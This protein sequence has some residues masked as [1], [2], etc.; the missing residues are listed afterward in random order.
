MSTYLSNHFNS[1]YRNC[2]KYGQSRRLNTDNLDI[3]LCHLLCVL[4]KKDCI[5]L[6]HIYGI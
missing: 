5:D 4:L 6:T 2:V 3:R 1:K